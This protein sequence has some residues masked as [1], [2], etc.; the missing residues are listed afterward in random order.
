MADEL[1]EDDW[2]YLE[3]NIA[4]N[5]LH[6]HTKK[7]HADCEHCRD[8]RMAHDPQPQD[9]PSREAARERLRR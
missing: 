5:A 2:G 4:Y 7:A 9:F 8:I 1:P 3:A 6:A